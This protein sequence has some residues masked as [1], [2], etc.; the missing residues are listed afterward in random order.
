MRTR[1]ISSLAAATLFVSACGGGA[2]GSQ[3]E[4]ADLFLASGQEEGLDLDKGCVED[5]TAKLSDDDAKKL[6]DAG[7][8][9]DPELSAAGEA[10]AFELAGCINADAL[11]DQM[12]EELG[13]DQN[14]DADCLE[15]ALD[16]FDPTSAEL[17]D[18]I[19]ECIT[20]G[21]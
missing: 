11:V 13:G 6:V 2:G 14:V 15:D 8:E 18:G 3:G 12:I 9:G 19:F 17:P 7:V 16:G 4:V 20:L 21:G 5:V 1:I 10:L